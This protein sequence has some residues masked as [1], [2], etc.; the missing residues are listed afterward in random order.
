MS[1]L[2][3]VKGSLFSFSHYEYTLVCPQMKTSVK[4][5][6]TDFEDL[7]NLLIKLFP[8]IYVSKIYCY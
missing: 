6:D 7:R 2:Q 1:S 5:K 8:A 4:R 3:Y